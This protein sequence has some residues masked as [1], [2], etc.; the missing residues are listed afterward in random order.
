MYSDTYLCIVQVLVLSPFAN[1][2]GVL[3]LTQSQ[4]KTFIIVESLENIT[5]N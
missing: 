4:F 5:I 3:P 2:W 1:S